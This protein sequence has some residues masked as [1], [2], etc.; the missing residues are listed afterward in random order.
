M[1]ITS[2]TSDKYIEVFGA[3]TGVIYVFLEI[4][5]SIW[6]WPV[7]IITSVLYIWVFFYR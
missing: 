7:G 1:E 4:R 5:Q 3:V 2:W 6:L